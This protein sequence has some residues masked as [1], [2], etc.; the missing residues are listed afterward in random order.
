MNLNT[1][2]SD[3]VR[4]I[5]KSCGHP[6][7]CHCINCSHKKADVMW[8]HIF[9][10]N[11]ICLLCAAVFCMFHKSLA[12]N[13]YFP[14]CVN[15]FLFW[16]AYHHLSTPLNSSIS[17]FPTLCLCP[18]A[19]TSCIFSPCVL[20]IKFHVFS[21][22]SSQTFLCTF[23]VAAVLRQVHGH[24]LACKCVLLDDIGTPMCMCL[25][26]RQRGRD[27]TQK[28]RGESSKCAA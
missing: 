11:H 14:L 19:R 8:L 2:E 28:K 20:S 18:G 15:M 9:V 16:S 12:L 21:N 3:W 6:V 22:N 7:N 27:E 26:V 1:D 24:Y 23:V 4:Y 17:L 13:E 10:V 25:C 5:K